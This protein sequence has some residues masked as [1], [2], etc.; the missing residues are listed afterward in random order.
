MTSKRFL[1]EYLFEK[2][3]YPKVTCKTIS[4]DERK[5]ISC[6]NSRTVDD[7]FHLK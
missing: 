6:G 3:K 7:S 2:R 5:S 4:A 1:N